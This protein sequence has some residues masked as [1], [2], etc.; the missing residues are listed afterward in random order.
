MNLGRNAMQNIQIERDISNFLH[1][2]G[3][4]KMGDF[5]GDV[6]EVYQLYNVTK[7]SDWVLDIVGA[8]DVAN[9]RLVRMVYLMSKIAQIYG[10]GLYKLNCQFKT[11]PAKMEKIHREIRDSTS[12]QLA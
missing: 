10:S 4:D 3:Y 12:S 1:E 11:L 7:E 8:D 5:L 9:V 6:M 2:W